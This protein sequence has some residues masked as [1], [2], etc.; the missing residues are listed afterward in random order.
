M[1][2][3]WCVFGFHRYRKWEIIEQGR[4]VFYEGDMPHGSYYELK[5]ICNNCGKIKI[6]RITL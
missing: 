2:I 3:N 1:K 4:L 6:K 5:A